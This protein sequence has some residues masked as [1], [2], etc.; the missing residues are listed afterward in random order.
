[1][2]FILI[3]GLDESECGEYG[4]GN[5]IF[6]I[7]SGKYN[8]RIFRHPQAI[9]RETQSNNENEPNS[10]NVEKGTFSQILFHFQYV[11]FNN[12]SNFFLNCHLYWKRASRKEANGSRLSGTMI[13]QLIS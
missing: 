13:V 3:F 2:A 4:K 12:R 1:V 8:K 9:F 5:V 10:F 7:G 11:Y 6:A